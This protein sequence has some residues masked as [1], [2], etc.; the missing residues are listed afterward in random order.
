MQKTILLIKEFHHLKNLLHK[1]VKQ[2][3]HK[4]IKI[5]HFDFVLIINKCENNTIKI[6]ISM[7]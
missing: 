2:L 6:N 1:L 4:K 7:K 3:L 5:F